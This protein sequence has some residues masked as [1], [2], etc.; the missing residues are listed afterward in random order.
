MPAASLI[1]VAFLDRIGV[2]H[3]MT[4]PEADSMIPDVSWKAVVLILGLVTVLM[5]GVIIL[6]HDG[7]DVT[8]VLG[9]VVT[10]FLVIISIF[11]AR[12]A[13]TIQSKVDQA[14]TK[15]DQVKEQNNG[16]MDQLLNM[17]KDLQEKNVALATQVAP[18]A[19]IAPIAPTPISPAGPTGDNLP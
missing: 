2:I 16:R 18:V 1:V 14:T 3:S 9:A 12:Q 17:V 6:A 15:V 19:P 13:Q 7:K 8:A 4:T 10:T 11:G 5:T